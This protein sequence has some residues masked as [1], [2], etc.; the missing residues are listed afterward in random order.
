[1]GNRNSAVVL[2]IVLHYHGPLPTSYA[3]RIFVSPGCMPYAIFTSTEELFGAVYHKIVVV[4]LS[5]PVRRGGGLVIKNR[6]YL[7]THGESHPESLHI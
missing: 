2:S 4:Y 3:D 6:I 7:A 5:P 1:M